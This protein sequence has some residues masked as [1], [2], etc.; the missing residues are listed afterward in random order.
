MIS[1]LRRS[2]LLTRNVKLICYLAP[3]LDFFN[4]RPGL[5]ECPPRMSARSDR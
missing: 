4:E 3:T 1:K 5:N 2:Y